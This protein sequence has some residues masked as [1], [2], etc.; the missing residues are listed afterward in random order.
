M[1]L[2]IRYVNISKQ[3]LEMLKHGSTLTVEII[4]KYTI[5]NNAS[6][7]KYLCKQ[8]VTMERC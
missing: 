5:K 7:I 4:F 3:L 1:R 6:D 2:F 8:E